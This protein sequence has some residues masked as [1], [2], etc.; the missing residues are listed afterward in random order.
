MFIYFCFEFGNRN[1]LFPYQIFIPR[2]WIVN[3]TIKIYLT[4]KLFWLLLWFPSLEKKNTENESVAR[5]L[6]D[7]L[8]FLC[9]YVCLDQ[10]DTSNDAG[11]WEWTGAN[12]YRASHWWERSCD[13]TVKE[14]SHRR[15][16]RETGLL[17]PGREWVKSL[18]LYS[19]LLF[20]PVTASNCLNFVLKL[21]K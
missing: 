5:L 4:L 17:Q 3:G 20:F 2:I 19:F 8:L 12:G 10:R 21:S 13:G 15:P 6:N 14:P 7:P 16:W 9:V 1:A 18:V 11:Q